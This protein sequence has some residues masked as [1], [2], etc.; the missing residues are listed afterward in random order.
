MLL[1]ERTRKS[2]KRCVTHVAVLHFLFS[3]WWLPRF[4]NLTSF[5]K[6]KASAKYIF[7]LKVPVIP[8]LNGQ[9]QCKR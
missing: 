4:G 3:S 5:L 2:A 9:P 6:R 1:L 7:P 8:P